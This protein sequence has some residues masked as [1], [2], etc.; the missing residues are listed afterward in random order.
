MQKREMSQ[1]R[2]FICEKIRHFL[3]CRN[4]KGDCSRVSFRRCIQYLLIHHTKLAK[5]HL[6]KV[7][8]MQQGR[9]LCGGEKTYQASWRKGGVVENHSVVL[10]EQAKHLPTK[11][12][13]E[14]LSQT[15]TPWVHRERSKLQ[16][17]LL[18]L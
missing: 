12:G 8:I 3:A 1:G 5:K 18:L 15:S 7:E 11:L 14:L 6:Q 10:Q 9:I 13:Q 4:A 2:I 16:K 17:L